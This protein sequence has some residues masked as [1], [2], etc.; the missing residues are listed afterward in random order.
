VGNAASSERL[1]GVE[2]CFEP[3]NSLYAPVS[4]MQ[5]FQL[6]LKRSLSFQ[7][8]YSI[9]ESVGIMVKISP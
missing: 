1:R 7:E 6:V 9:T 5:D 4:T 2:G 3:V 8:Q